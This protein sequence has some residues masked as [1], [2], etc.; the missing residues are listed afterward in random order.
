LS[1]ANLR[2]FAAPIDDLSSLRVRVIND[3]YTRN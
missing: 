3:S 1:L 2:S